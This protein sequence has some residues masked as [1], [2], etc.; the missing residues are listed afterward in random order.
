MS[1]GY[2]SPIIGRIG[3]LIRDQIISRNYVP[4][5]S[6]WAILADGF[7]EF[8]DLVIRGEFRTGDTG[9]RIEI[10]DDLGI[11]RVLLY[12]G[13]TN[14]TEP[15]WVASTVQN[16]PGFGDIS[17]GAIKSSNDGAGA[18][19]FNL[20]APQSGGAGVLGFA[21]SGPQPAVVL[22]DDSAAL[23][24][25]RGD[26]VTL[27][28]FSHAAQ[29]GVGS[30]PNLA[31]DRATVQARDNGA[32]ADLKINPLGRGYSCPGMRHLDALDG[33]SRSTTSTTFVTASTVATFTFPCPPSKT[34]TVAVSGRL[35]IS[36][37]A[38]ADA[39]ALGFE[40]R[41]GSS[42]GSVLFAAGD[43]NAAIVRQTTVP[44]PGARLRTVD[45]T[46]VGG[47]N[48][49]DTLWISAMLRSNNAA[50]TAT[51][52]QVTLVVMPSP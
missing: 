29:F 9:Q 48:P 20:Y 22:V 32:A 5:I 45:L 24:C 43:N 16:T 38:A 39:A 10:R 14:E 30:G 28:G 51:M 2:A 46:G 44:Q 34:F 27:A 7:A 11:S 26:A 15:M 31:F 36:T 40:V 47:V 8:L 23:R 52:Q 4:G 1:E 21:T 50:N 19:F 49:G 6:G 33:G 17:V 12:S 42:G 25:D 13:D 37:G 35:N 3:T 18:V 41:A